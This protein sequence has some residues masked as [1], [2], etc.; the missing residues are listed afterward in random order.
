MKRRD[1]LRSTAAVAGAIVA[2]RFAYAL[3][4]T[5]CSAYGGTETWQ[6]HHQSCYDGRSDGVPVQ[7]LQDSLN[8]LKAVKGNQGHP[9][10][11]L[12][13]LNNS[14]SQIESVMKAGQFRPE[15]RQAV[16]DDLNGLGPNGGSGTHR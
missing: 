2:S 5:G 1:F 7:Q 10:Q 15:D 12:H 4:A 6:R 9:L 3:N 11:A 16:L 14:K 13:A 8:E